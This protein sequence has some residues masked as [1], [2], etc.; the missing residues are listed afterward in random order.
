MTMF[1]SGTIAHSTRTLLLPQLLQTL[2]RHQRSSHSQCFPPL[3]NSTSVHPT[4]TS[5]HPTALHSLVEST[6]I[7]I[8]PPTSRIIYRLRNHFNSPSNLNLAYNIQAAPSSKS[9]APSSESLASGST[10]ASAGS[11]PAGRAPIL[12]WI[13]GITFSSFE[14]CISYSV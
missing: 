5:P 2:H 3:I 13:L 7:S 9:S 11:V 14:I 1:T 12:L 6:I 8:H 10:T 4:F